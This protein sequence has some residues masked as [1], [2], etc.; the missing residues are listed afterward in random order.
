MRVPVWPICWICGRQPRLVATR[1]TPTAAPSTDASSS[2]IANASA[3]PIPRPPPT[4]TLGAA[5]ATTAP[6]PPPPPHAALG[7]GQRPASA[8]RHIAPDDPNP[9]IGIRDR[10][11]DTR[12]GH[13][14]R[15]S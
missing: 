14:S 9:E 6:P 10:R 12:H 4:T 7:V 3:L 2:S 8:S 15:G 5:R 11:G 1:D 13:L